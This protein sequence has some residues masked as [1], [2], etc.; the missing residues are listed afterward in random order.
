M[1]GVVGGRGDPI[2]QRGEQGGHADAQG[3]PA[4][5]VELDLLGGRRC[6]R[7]DDRCEL[8]TTARSGAGQ[9]AARPA[10]RVRTGDG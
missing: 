8:A 7:C 4:P 2:E 1:L 3:T 6:H 5:G 10:E 9:P